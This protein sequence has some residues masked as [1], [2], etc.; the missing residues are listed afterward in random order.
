MTKNILDFVK[1]KK[2]YNVDFFAKKKP[3]WDG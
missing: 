3:T 2:Y 1:V